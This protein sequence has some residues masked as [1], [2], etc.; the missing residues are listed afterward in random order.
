MAPPWL[1]A[2]AIKKGKRPEID[3]SC[4]SAYK[5]LIV[6]CWQERCAAEGLCVHPPRPLKRPSFSEIV[7]RLKRLLD[8][9]E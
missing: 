9:L 8:E 4:P 7:A 2:A 3:A 5:S 6:D 1:M